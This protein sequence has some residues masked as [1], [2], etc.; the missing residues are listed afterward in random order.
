[1]NKDKITEYCDKAIQNA[2]RIKS[3]T[4]ELEAFFTEHFPDS[5]CDMTLKG[6]LQNSPYLEIYLYFKDNYIRLTTLK[7]N[8]QFNFEYIFNRIWDMYGTDDYNNFHIVAKE[9]YALYNKKLTLEEIKKLCLDFGK[10][11]ELK[12]CTLLMQQKI[13]EYKINKDFK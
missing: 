4:A 1:M 5:R 8:T 13:K 6:N 3:I 7:K 12:E 9:F 2:T 10:D 11:M